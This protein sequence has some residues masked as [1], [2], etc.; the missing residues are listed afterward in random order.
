M[1]EVARFYS[2]VEADLARLLL[3]SHGI[4]SFLLDTQMSNFFGGVM[5]PVRLLVI[6][7]DVREAVAILAED[8]PISPE[9][10]APPAPG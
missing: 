2:A 10:D 5:T 9:E 6:E 8:R 1:I 7:E 3:D 4:E